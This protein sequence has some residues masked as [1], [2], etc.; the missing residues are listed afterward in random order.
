MLTKHEEKVTEKIAWFYEGVSK[1]KTSKTQTLDPRPRKVRPR[2]VR[3]RKVRPR[4]VRPRKV[5]PRKVRPRKV[6]PRKVRPRKVRPRKYIAVWIAVSV[7]WPY[8]VHPRNNRTMKQLMEHAVSTLWGVWL[9]SGTII[10]YKEVCHV[11]AHKLIFTFKFVNNEHCLVMLDWRN[12]NNLC[13]SKA[14]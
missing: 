14:Y 6:R 10:R 13:H 1:S 7:Q 4:K 12:F 3:P 9:L 8:T 2:K 11:P 5:R